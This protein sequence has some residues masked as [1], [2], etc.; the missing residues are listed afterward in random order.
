MSPKEALRDSP[1]FFT[2]ETHAVAFQVGDALFCTF[3]NDLNGMWV[4]EVIALFDRVCCQE[5]SSSMVASAALIPPAANEVWASWRG[6]FPTA[7]TRHRVRPI[8]WQ[9]EGPILRYR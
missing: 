1:I 5:S 6:R 4:R 9:H 8:R 3:G 7:R 2:R